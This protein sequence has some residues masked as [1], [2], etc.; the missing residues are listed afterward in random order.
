MRSKKKYRCAR[1]GASVRL[2]APEF[3]FCSQRCRLIDL[4]QWL[5][6][7]YRVPGRSVALP[8]RSELEDQESAS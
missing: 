6:G 7:A 8:E 3:P 2:N 4:G 5:D 1:C